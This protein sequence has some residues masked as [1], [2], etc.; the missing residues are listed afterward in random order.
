MYLCCI[1]PSRFVSPLLL[2]GAREIADHLCKMGIKTYVDCLE[3]SRIWV[4]V[5]KDQL[6]RVQRVEVGFRSTSLE[7]NMT[8]TSATNGGGLSL[9][10]FVA[11]LST[12][13]LGSYSLHW[14]CCLALKTLTDDVLFHIL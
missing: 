8:R 2:E 9:R 3:S 7:H 5:C 13:S 10:P 12:G 4:E 1:R 6:S 14:V 11:K